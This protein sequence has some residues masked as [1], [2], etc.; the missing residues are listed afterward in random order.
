MMG[1]QLAIQTTFRVQPQ[2]WCTVALEGTS[3]QAAP[4][5][6]FRDFACP[7]LPDNAVRN[8]NM[9]GNIQAALTVDEAGGACAFETHRR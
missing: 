8:L 7:Q 4:R 6:D 9:E 5:C 3:L 1:W 2:S